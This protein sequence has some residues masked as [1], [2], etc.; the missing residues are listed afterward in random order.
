MKSL[1]KMIFLSLIWC[2]FSNNFG[3]LNIVLAFLL[4]LLC[5]FLLRGEKD[6]HG[7]LMIG[8]L[9][10]LLG[11][12]LIELFKSSLAVAWEVITPK[13]R[14]TPKI[15]DV[16]LACRNDVECTLLANL[17]S[18]VPGT[19]SIDLS[20]DKTHLFIHVMFAKNPQKVICYI[21]EKLEP[22]ILKVFKN[23]NS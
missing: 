9:F 17:T 7:R 1:W 19:L 10:L 16:P 3:L 11:F 18:L 15:I 23:G 13:P 2:G 6:S 22:K 21:K 4:S 5:C 8:P 14:S 12:I 20:E